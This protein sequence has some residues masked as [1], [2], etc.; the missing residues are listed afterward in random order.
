MSFVENI[1]KFFRRV[2]RSVTFDDEKIVR[3]MTNG[4]TE[5]VRWDE[6]LSVEITTTAG[7]PCSEDVFWILKGRTGAVLF[8]KAQKDQVN[9]SSSFKICQVFA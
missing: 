3:T 8:H 4:E 9:C 5:V 1:R 7:G 6:L 2:P